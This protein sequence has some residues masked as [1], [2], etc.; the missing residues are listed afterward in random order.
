VQQLKPEFY[1][2]DREVGG[3]IEEQLRLAVAEDKRVVDHH[4]IHVGVA[5]VNQRVAE[6]EKRCREAGDD[7]H[8]SPFPAKDRQPREGILRRIK[9]R[10][11]RRGLGC[12]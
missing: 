12:R 10:R 5:P 9:R 1:G 11:G 6:Q 7:R 8:Q 4:E 3:V 2:Q